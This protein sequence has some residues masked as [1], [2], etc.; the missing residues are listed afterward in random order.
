[1]TILTIKV[2]LLQEDQLD[3]IRH[4]IESFNHNKEPSSFISDYAVLELLGAGAF[5]AVHKVKKKNG[6]SYLAM[7]EVGDLIFIES[8][9]VSWI[10]N[11]AQQVA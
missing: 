2:I 5:G 3:D 7:K 11:D 8:R 1:M 4:D 10:K 9:D 6:Q